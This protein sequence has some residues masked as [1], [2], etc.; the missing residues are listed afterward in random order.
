MHHTIARLLICFYE[1][2]RTIPTF[3]F[4]K[5]AT[6]V[7]DNR[8]LLNEKNESSRFEHPSD[9]AVHKSCWL[10][11]ADWTIRSFK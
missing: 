4:N 10:Y 2:T 11:I 9:L 3:A 5:A 6:E 8:P 1:G 7:T